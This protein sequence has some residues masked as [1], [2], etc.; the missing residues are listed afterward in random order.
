MI[1]GGRIIIGIPIIIRSVPTISIGG[2]IRI[3]TGP[4]PP[5]RIVIGI[6]PAPVRAK[7]HIYTPVGCGPRIPGIVPGIIPGIIII[8]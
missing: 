5:I 7:S 8:G 3:T 2:N 1:V 4:I 6:S